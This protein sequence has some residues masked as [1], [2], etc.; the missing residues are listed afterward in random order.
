MTAAEE[1]VYGIEAVQLMKQGGGQDVLPELRL[2][3]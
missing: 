1:K 2:P 3:T